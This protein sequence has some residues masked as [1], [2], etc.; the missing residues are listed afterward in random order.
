MFYVRESQDL[1]D[2]KRKLKR[3]N[4]IQKEFHSAFNCFLKQMKEFVKLIKSAPPE[5]NTDG[6]TNRQHKIFFRADMISN[7]K[8]E[9]KV[10]RRRA[11]LCLKIL[12]NLKLEAR[13]LLVLFHST[14]QY[15]RHVKT[16]ER[17]QRYLKLYSKSFLLLNK[18]LKYSL[19]KK[20]GRFTLCK[21]FI[22]SYLFHCPLALLTVNFYP[23]IAIGEMLVLRIRSWRP[24]LFVLQW[25]NANNSHLNLCHKYSTYVWN[26]L[27]SLK[28]SS[29][30]STVRK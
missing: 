16:Y 19:D 3:F 18:Y 27:L 7:R 4:A 20:A 15:V 28:M 8:V 22:H 10:L 2:L 25:T 5:R 26:C 30:C 17:H 1:H 6:S 24:R 29:V 9:C 13:D 12:L 11:K 21:R 14:G 23:W